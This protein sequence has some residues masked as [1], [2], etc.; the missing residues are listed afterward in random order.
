MLEKA[1]EVG[2]GQFIPLITEHCVAKASA[3]TQSDKLEKWRAV[4]IRACKQSHNAWLPTMPGLMSLSEWLADSCTVRIAGALTDDATPLAHAL[5]AMSLDA[6]TTGIAI[7][8]EGDFSSDEYEQLRRNGVHM[9]SLGDR[10]L[11]CETAALYVL[12]A[13]QYELERQH[14]EP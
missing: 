10:V 12:N 8:P 14:H 1:A 11:R 7:G 6:D 4:F 2:V 3:K 9:V 5:P 13:V